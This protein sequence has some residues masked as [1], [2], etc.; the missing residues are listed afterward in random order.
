[1]FRRV[2]VVNRGEPAMRAIR[3]IR[4]L[5]AEGATIRSIALCTEEECDA[6]FVR[7]ADE[8]HCLGPA[9]ARPYLD[10]ST[11]ERALVATGA[12]AAW[13]GW[14][15]VAEDPAFAELCARIGVTFVGP[16]A[17]VMRR[18]GDKVAAK[19]L[20][21]SVGVPVAAWSRGA[22]ADLAAARDAARRIGYP[23]VLKA[24]AGGGGRGIRIVH[25]EDELAAVYDRARREAAQAFGD[26]AVFLER[27][28]PGSRHVEVQ[29]LADGQGTAWALGVRDCS[30]QRRNQKI[31]EESASPLLSPEQVAGLKEVARRLVLSADYRGAAT[32]EFLH[33]PRTGRSSFLE[34]NTR[35]QVEH[36]VTEATTGVDLVKAQLR[37]AA[38]QPLRGPEPAESG[39][40]IEVRLNAEDPD[41]DFAP[42]PGRVK[43]F[44]P[45][46]GPGIRVDAGFAVGDAVPPDYDSMI[47]KIVAFGDTREEALSRA[48]RALA[49]TTVLVEGGTTNKGLLLDLLAAPE[50]VDATADIGWVD[51][52]RDQ[53]RR[54][55]PADRGIALVAAAIDGYLTEEDAR[56][57]RL[58]ADARRGAPRTTP[59]DVPTTSLE[60]GS[61]AH[62]VRVARTGP[63]RFRVAVD[64]AERA[65]DVRFDRLDPAKAR[66]RLD[67]GSF[68]VVVD[69]SG[70]QRLVEVAGHVHRVG[71]GDRGVLRSPGPALVVAAPAAE[72]EEVAAGDPVLV[73]ESMKT[74]TVLRAPFP[75][76][77]TELLVAVGH[78]VAADAA[79]A[80]LEPV[81][82]ERRA[83]AA[84]DLGLSPA[85]APADPARS[86]ADLRNALLGY[87]PDPVDE[88]R[89]PHDYATAHRG[90]RP[91]AAE[92]ELLHLFADIADLTRRAPA[93]HDDVANPREQFHAYLRC[94]DVDAAGTAPAFRDRLRRILGHHGITD[95]ARCEALEA[96]VFRVHLAQQRRT[97]TAEAASAVLRGWLTG[98]PPAEDLRDAVEGVLERLVT[99]LPDAFGGVAELAR[100]VLFHR[101]V[102]P[103]A[104]R[105]RARAYARAREHL[106]HLDENPAAPDRERRIA[107]VTGCR[108]PLEPL[109][110]RRID[111]TGVELG[112]LLEALLRRRVPARVRSFEVD[113]RTFAAA[114]REGALWLTTAAEL[115]QL[116]A[117]AGASAKVA[118]ERAPG[119]T[120]VDIH[121]GGPG[122]WPDPDTAAA[123][124]AR[125]LDRAAPRG[126]VRRWTLSLLDASGSRHF[127]FRPRP[128]G[129]VEARG[130][131][132]VHPALRERLGLW[133]LREFDVTRL[134]SVDEDV[135]LFRCDRDSTVDSLVAVALVRDPLPRRD[136]DGR[137]VA[138]PGAE[139][140]LAAATESVVTAPQRREAQLSRIFLETSA[141]TGL[142]AEDLNGIAHRFSPALRAGVA[143]IRFRDGGTE[144]HVRREPTSARIRVRAVPTAP[145]EPVNDLGRR[146]LRAHRRG[147]AHPVDLVDL[148]TRDGGSF[149]E[150]DLDD[151]GALLPVERPLGRHRAGI[152]VGVANTPTPRHPA[153]ARRVVLLGDPTRALGALAEP[154]CARVIAALDLAERMRVAVEWYALSAG[155]KISMDSGTENMDWVAAALKRIVEFTQGGGEINVVVA[156]INVG[157]QPYWNAE[158]TMLMHTK[159]I[160]VMTPD[161]AMVLTGKKALDFSGGVSAEDNYGIGGHDR[162]MGPNGQAQH[163]A[164]DLAGALDVLLAHYDHTYVT[165]GEPGPRRIATT[166][167]ADRDIRD[168]PHEVADC[169]LTAVGDIFSA[170]HNPD[171]KKP[172][173]IRTLLR[174]VSDQDHPVLERW[175]AMAGAETA[176]VTDAHLG[177]FPVCLLGVESRPLCRLG[178][179]PTDGPATHTAGTLFPLSAKK[180][181]RA[182]N[183]AS[184]NRPLV[185]LANLSGFDGSP[186]SM[187]TLQLEHGAEIARAVVNFRGPIV[188]CVVS[189][190]HG[191]AFVVF[192][193][194]L[195]PNMTVL[196]VTGSHASVLGGAPAAA[197]V[198]AGEVDA[199]TDRDPRVRRAAPD[200]APR[201]RESVRVEKLTEVAAEFDAV[202]DVRRTVEVGS[203][204]EIVEPAEVRPRIIAA[205]ER[206]LDG[207]GR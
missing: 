11:L 113:G 60:L 121:L 36:P 174:A 149:T 2:A 26:D 142:T 14:G 195:N 45:P 33:D 112:P 69:R 92:V 62:R 138:L 87:D 27:L 34:V 152:V 83:P 10:M 136:A 128:D 79:L 28:L 119:D 49:E 47:A 7:A 38:G 122:P 40:A 86:A 156:G 120:D 111:R 75:A 167:P 162:V 125:A 89:I 39:H 172:F 106:R 197:V 99:A 157:A 9:S 186:E 193:K 131:R 44:D 30:V 58:L 148:L 65:V 85:G 187:R 66:V 115:D 144:F 164:P 196:A 63:D 204:D 158:A 43:R 41:R 205:L 105:A 176:V 199:R 173:D 35:L 109:L 114:E 53:R 206:G 134:P 137:V 124:L 8:A 50:I 81:G 182:I 42:A 191:G 110:A 72:G 98:P 170:E 12:E 52:A 46:A 76:R 175:A 127:T 82:A 171:R 74:E 4:E 169:D 21:E 101:I 88:Q 5:D 202:H 77:L 104:R 140:A 194:A 18:L 166:D 198:F 15:F 102:Q 25:D 90:A 203:V 181:A 135:H 200:E 78:Q 48:R 168:H 61:A 6:A 146:V 97:A 188:F 165:P 147:T 155:A 37:V 177:G 95:L 161:S 132:D 207:R 3:A 123:E 91:V 189:R 153:G 19:Q 67:S 151:T 24:A 130:E 183:A 179:P 51:R 126:E 184:G 185:V 73:L 139:T 150:H 55:V 32:V 22:V 17:A 71:H 84:A 1:M 100:R 107:A 117:T 108:E 178:F 54:N 103:R 180:V 154:E 116:Q 64:D 192:S 96:A 190:Y 145:V 160:L 93:P 13:P 20:A 143:E 56:R 70:E 80:R 201:V 94:L 57:R 141:P 31:I 16:D 133:R 129:V 59:D 29:V 68:D 163:W 118:G 159:G 23:L